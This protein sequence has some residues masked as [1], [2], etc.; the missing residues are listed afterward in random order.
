MA[1]KKQEKSELKLAFEIASLWSEEQITSYAKEAN[2]KDRLGSVVL[3]SGLLIAMFS[4]VV[5]ALVLG[6]GT[7]VALIVGMIF[8]VALLLGTIWATNFLSYDACVLE[9]VMQLREYELYKLEK[10]FAK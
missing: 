10:E 9:K 2:R 1:K 6:P 7:A 5:T 4:T 8:F 3:I